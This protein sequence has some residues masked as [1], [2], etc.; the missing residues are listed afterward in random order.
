MLHGRCIHYTTPN[1]LRDIQF[2]I[3]GQRQQHGAGGAG[4]V[5][6]R[7]RG[8]Q[9]QGTRAIY[10][11]VRAAA[12]AEQDGLSA[13][14]APLPET[15]ATAAVPL[16]LRTPL[17]E[18]QQVG[19]EEGSVIVV[20]DV[21]RDCCIRAGGDVVVLGRLD[22]SA[23]AA[24]T[25]SMVAALQFGPTAQLSVNG[26]SAQVPVDTPT[27]LMAVLAD[28]RGGVVFK[29][30]PASAAVAAALDGQQQQQQQQPE[31]GLRKQLLTQLVPAAALMLG[32]GLTAAPSAVLGS[33]IGTSGESAVGALLETLVYGETVWPWKGLG[34]YALGHGAWGEPRWL[35]AHRRPPADLPLHTRPRSPCALNPPPKKNPPGYILLQGAGLLSEGSELLLEVVDPGIIG[36]VL[37]PCLGALPDALIVLNSG[38]KGTR[39][40]AQEQLAVGMG[41]LAGSTVLLLSLAWGLGVILGRCDLDDA[42]GRAVDK[43]LTRGFDLNRTG[44]TTEVGGGVCVRGGTG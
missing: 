9:S 36:G 10:R 2:V 24:G 33:L 42:S 22:G 38:L 37:L 29:Q 39:D 43:T 18:G 34:G 13:A 20:G 23:H 44:V 30:L 31:G 7:C 28:D 19:H 15:A 41:T 6:G 25:N 14:A 26:V 8:A 32:V 35:L 16:Y 4:R 5:V 1:A 27:L 3:S 11:Q 40:T 12:A 17:T 21:P